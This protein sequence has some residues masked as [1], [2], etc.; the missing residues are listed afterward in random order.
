[1]LQLLL[2]DGWTTRGSRYT[3]ITDC[4]V[5]IISRIALFAATTKVLFVVSTLSLQA[6]CRG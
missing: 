6:A 3:W 4:Y 1:M 5:I 2:K